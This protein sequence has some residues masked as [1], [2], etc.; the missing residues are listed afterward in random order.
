MNGGTETCCG[1]QSM[2]DGMAHNH[3][4]AGSIPAS[5]TTLC[6]GDDVVIRG[7]RVIGGLTRVETLDQDDV[8]FSGNTGTLVIPHERKDGGRQPR[9]NV[10]PRPAAAHS[11]SS[12]TAPAARP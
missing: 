9:L 10:Q 11:P 8:V 7:N 12:S 3:S 1:V 4:A 2:V 5:A 6:S